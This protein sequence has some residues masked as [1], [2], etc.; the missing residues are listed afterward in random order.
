[1]NESMHNQEG[2]KKKLAVV[3]A[4]ISTIAVVVLWLVFLPPEV[5]SD[6]QD[7]QTKN[8]KIFRTFIQV[9]GQQF[10]EMSTLFEDNQSSLEASLEN[11]EQ[12]YQQPSQEE[13]PQA[14]TPT[15]TP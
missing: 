10:E 14:A 8:Q 2:N 4:A 6:T 13:E 7:T 9:T 3:L 15:T 12:E 1:M 11:A 5:S